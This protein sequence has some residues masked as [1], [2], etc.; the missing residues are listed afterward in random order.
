MENPFEIFKVLIVSL[1]SFQLVSCGTLMYPERRGQ[2][3]GR[4][5]VGVTIL[6]ALGLL[7]GL[8]PGII[9][10]AVDFST[11]CI[12]LPASQS[13]KSK[14]EG[15]RVVKFDKDHYSKEQLEAIISRETGKHFHFDDK[16]VRYS[17]LKNTD[18]LAQYFAEFEQSNKQ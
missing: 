15:F 13:A 17:E 9:A 10:F 1:L 4:L 11:G 16:R 5:D 8:I 3:V 2:K 6:D 7:L 12:Y 18:E 14:V